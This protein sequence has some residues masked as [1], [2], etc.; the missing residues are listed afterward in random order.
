MLYEVITEP[1]GVR[2]RR[3]KTGRAVRRLEDLE[4]RKGVSDAESETTG[5]QVPSGQAKDP[6]ETVRSRTQHLP[7]MQTG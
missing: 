5:L 3:G 4:E 6:Q 2:L 7:A 1:D